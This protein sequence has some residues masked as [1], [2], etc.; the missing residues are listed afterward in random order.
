MERLRLHNQPGA[1]GSRRV[2]LGRMMLS[3]QLVVLLASFTALIIF[4]QSYRAENRALLSQLDL[5]AEQSGMVIDHPEDIIQVAH[6]VCVLETEIS[7]A[8]SFLQPISATLTS[9]GWCGNYTRVFIEYARSQGFP[10]QKIHLR[11]GHR[12]HTNAEVYYQGKW[13]AVDPFFGILFPKADGDLASVNE[14][15]ADPALG[16]GEFV[17][18]YED[19]QLGKIY[20]SYDA[21]FGKLYR[22]ALD[23]QWQLN[24]SAFFHNSVI[25]LSYPVALISEGPRRPIIPYWLDRPNLLG[26]YFAGGVFLVTL[27]VLAR[28]LWLRRRRAEAPVQR[29]ADLNIGH[30][31]PN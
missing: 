12:S 4:L 15:A 31:R 16:N 1:A 2:L 20:E 25:I 17:L 24:G 26:A 27:L 3:L 21:I 30:I 11:T 28:N 5:I 18:S 6:S 19:P 10:A 7:S 9:G 8:Q 29:Y 14:I 22:D 13:R 23:F